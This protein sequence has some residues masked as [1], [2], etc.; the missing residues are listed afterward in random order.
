M[1][2][3]TLIR[4]CQKNAA[5]SPVRQKWGF[6]NICLGITQLIS[7]PPECHSKRPDINTTQLL[8]KVWFFYNDHFIHV[9]HP[10]GILYHCFNQVRILK[11][12]SS[13]CFWHVPLHNTRAWFEKG[14]STKNSTEDTEIPDGASTHICVYVSESTEAHVDATHYHTYPKMLAL[15]HTNMSQTYGRG[16]K[17][18]ACQKR[19]ACI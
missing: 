6:S 17:K 19:H 10:T 13:N 2:S 3:T 11:C 18:H 15:C 7:L 14:L 4:T 9:S 12:T 5:Y 16:N 8:Q 1:T